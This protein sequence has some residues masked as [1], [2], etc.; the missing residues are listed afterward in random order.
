MHLIFAKVN[1][2]LADEIKELTKNIP[3]DDFRYRKNESKY[4]GI[5]I[6][7]YLKNAD[8]IRPIANGLKDKAL[9]RDQAIGDDQP[10]YPYQLLD[11]AREIIKELDLGMT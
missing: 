5:S 9:F 10:V 1:R 8:N 6:N 2:H 4:A 7:I 11:K 3:K